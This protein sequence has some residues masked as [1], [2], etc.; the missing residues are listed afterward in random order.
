MTDLTLGSIARR[1]LRITVCL[2]FLLL[3]GLAGT[4]LFGQQ[5]SLEQRQPLELV[6]ADSIVPQDRHEM[7][8][9]TGVWYFRH[10]DLRNASLTQKIE[11]GISDQLQI[12]T[13]VHL[14]NR[15]N[16]VDAA[17]TG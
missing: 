16:Q 14:V 3:C 5:E 1:L 17:M 7:M 9:T 4:S 15:S 13:F 11:W 8:T 2:L 6:F 10:G 12:S